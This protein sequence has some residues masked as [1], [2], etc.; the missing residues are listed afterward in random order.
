MGKGAE[1]KTVEGNWEWHPVLGCYSRMVYKTKFDNGRPIEC[2][3]Q[4]R[5]FRKEHMASEWF[6]APII[7]GG[8]FMRA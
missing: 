4:W 8:S 1:I 6:A 3:D 5:E 7:T 2:L